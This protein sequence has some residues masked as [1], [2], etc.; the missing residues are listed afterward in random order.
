MEKFNVV[1]GVLVSYTGNEENVVIPSK[2]T[3]IGEK[4]FSENLK[5]KTVTINEGVKEISNNAF[6]YCDNLSSVT[7]P[8]TL[9]VIRA[10]AFLDCKN[11]QNV[12]LPKG[13]K[14][15]YSHAF[16]NTGIEEITLPSS[17]DILGTLAFSGFTPIKNINVEKGNSHFVSDNGVLYNKDKTCLF[18]YPQG[19][20]E[21]KFIVPNGVKRISDFAFGL[22]SN[23]TIEL[24]EGVESIGEK[25]FVCPSAKDLYLPS[26]LKKIER[27]ALL[28]Y[29]ASSY[30]TVYVK[31]NSYA[32]KYI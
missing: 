22:V 11:L 26:S 10:K 2:V 14:E 15:L 6:E 23:I 12:T 28:G 29:G 20:K 18:M 5:I 9:K 25:T 8:S 7:L 30:P 13:L 31:K 17:L 21:G 1:N 19:R 24:T 32:E 3:I 27:D 4:A 16:F